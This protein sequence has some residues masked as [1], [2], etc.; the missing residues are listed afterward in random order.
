MYVYQS[1]SA[2]S[3]VY[4]TTA[5]P[6]LICDAIHCYCMSESWLKERAISMHRSVSVAGSNVQSGS[7]VITGLSTDSQAMSAPGPTGSSVNYS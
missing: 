4:N 1:H 2:S 5:C 6:V 3:F 7:A